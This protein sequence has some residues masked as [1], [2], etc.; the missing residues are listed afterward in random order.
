MNVQLF[1]P[2]FIDQLYPDVAFDSIKILEK[3]Q[4]NVTYNPNQTCCGQP[5]YNAG[6]KEDACD[7]YKKFLTDFNTQDYIVCPSASCVGF[8][9]NY[10]AT[11]T[12]QNIPLP[13]FEL[14]EF[15]V[16][17]LKI[18]NL[19]ATF[20]GNVAYHS[21]CASL[22][23]CIIKD[24]PI[25]LLKNVQGLHLIPFAENETC[26]GFGGSFAV[27]FEA[28]SSAMGE[29]KINHIKNVHATTIT[30]TDMSCLLHLEGIIKKNNLS[31]E[32]KHIAQILANF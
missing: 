1:I 3:L 9:K 8:L 19:N 25:S 20:I 7:V 30:S 17:I 6:F 5:A 4:C 11:M 28:I 29:Q 23:E 10:A 21:S 27:K 15:I 12:P 2:C 26:C 32:V 31:I 24:A 22:R 13:I 14:T 16:D 18:T